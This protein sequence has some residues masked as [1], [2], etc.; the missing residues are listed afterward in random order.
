M[1]PRV[2]SC[3]AAAAPCMMRMLG[4]RANRR[5]KTRWAAVVVAWGIAKIRRVRALRRSRHV[6]V[7]WA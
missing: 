2:F 6:I 1:R 5:F 3:G 4:A 7:P